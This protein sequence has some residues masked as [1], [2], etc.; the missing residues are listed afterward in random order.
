MSTKLLFPMLTRKGGS[1]RVVI[2]T[3][4]Q[5]LL[6]VVAMNGF[7]ERCLSM[8]FGFQTHTLRLDTSHPDYW[9]IRLDVECA[10]DRARTR[11]ENQSK[12]SRFKMILEPN[13]EIKKHF[14]LSS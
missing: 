11:N 6:S 9:Q 5:L 2:S 10:I 13:P 3:S 8:T 4:V 1:I 7:R 12:C 14:G